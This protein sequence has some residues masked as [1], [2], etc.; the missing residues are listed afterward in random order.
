[1]SVYAILKYANAVNTIIVTT[2]G[3]VTM[4]FSAYILGTS[5]ENVNYGKQMTTVIPTTG[6][7]DQSTD[8][9]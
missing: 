6:D 7:V 2:G 8:E 5:Y 1:M 3:M 9:R 4:I